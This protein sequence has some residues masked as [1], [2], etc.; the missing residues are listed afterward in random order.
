[1]SWVGL[2]PRLASRSCPSAQ[3]LARST[4]VLS[5]DAQ[6]LSVA[7]ALGTQSRTFLS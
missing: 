6:E 7:K 5:T 2:G 1:M 4:K 3:G